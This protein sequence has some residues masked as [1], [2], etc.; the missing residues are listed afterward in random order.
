MQLVPYLAFDGQCR[1]AFAFYRQALGGRIV[2]ETSYGE[3]PVC[4][5]MPPGHHDRVMHMQLDAGGAILM[6]ADAPPGQLAG[7]ASQTCVN[8]T[9]DDPALAERVFAALAE[10]GTVQ[11]PIEETFWAHRF[12]M[13]VDRYGKPWMVNCL[14]PC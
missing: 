12:G 3:S 11:M 2:A 13:L 7:S 10:G 8:V 6:G 9:V 4:E 5:Q 14:K 1:E